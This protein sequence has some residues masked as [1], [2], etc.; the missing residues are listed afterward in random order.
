MRRS[1][2][3]LPETPGVRALTGYIRRYYEAVRRP[4]WLQ[5]HAGTLSRV[6]LT[7]ENMLRL[8]DPGFVSSFLGM[9]VQ[10]C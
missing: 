2:W 9:Y 3:G 10:T 4:C 5:K 7:S 6:L 1:G 8:G